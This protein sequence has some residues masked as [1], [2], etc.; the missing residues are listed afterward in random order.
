[1]YKNKQN[2]NRLTKRYVKHNL[3][4]NKLSNHNHKLSEFKINGW[5]KTKYIFYSKLTFNLIDEILYL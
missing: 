1:M 3:R 2:L 5:F 4:K